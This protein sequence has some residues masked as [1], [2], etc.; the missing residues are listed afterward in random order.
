[1]Q[2]SILRHFLNKVVYVELTNGSVHIGEL[3]YISIWN[4]DNPMQHQ[5][6]Y[7]IG[8]VGFLPQEVNVL[9]KI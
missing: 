9:R 5:N 4:R 8:D 6:M 7:Y 2:D 1:M 3:S